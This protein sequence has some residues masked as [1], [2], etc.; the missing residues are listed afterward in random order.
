MKSLLTKTL[1][2]ISSL[3]MLVACEKKVQ[4]PSN[5]AMLQDSSSV[6]MIKLNALLAEVEQEEMA[7]FVKASKDKYTLSSIGFWYAITSKGGGKP[8]M[9][10]NV[11]L[12]DYTVETLKGE[13]CYNYTREKAQ[14]LIVGKAQRERGLHEALEMMREGDRAIIVVPSNLCF[15]MLGD[16]N[17]VPPRTVLVYRVNGIKIK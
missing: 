4:M 8:I 6:D 7:G 17:K 1:V 3:L 15:G 16:A 5:K 2:L 12:L 11:V 13:V 10:S 9:K 14:K